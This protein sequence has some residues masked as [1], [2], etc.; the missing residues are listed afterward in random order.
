MANGD[1]GG[2]FQYTNRGTDLAST[3]QWQAGDPWDQHYTQ[4]GFEDRDRE[5]EDY[6]GNGITTRRFFLVDATGV[7]VG[8]FGDVGPF[9]NGTSLQFIHNN[10]GTTDSVI[11]WSQ[12]ETFA[13]A[14]SEL[15]FFGPEKSG[16][17]GGAPVVSFVVDVA[18]A[19][20]TT[21]IADSNVLILGTADAAGALTGEFDIL[22]SGATMFFTTVC[23]VLNLAGSAHAE[24]KASAFT[25]VS[26][27]REKTD[28]E[29]LDDD[30][31][32]DVVRGVR[33]HRFRYKVRPQT[34]IGSEPEHRRARHRI[35]RDHNCATDDCAGTVDSP[36]T[37]ILNDTPRIGLIAEDVHKVAPEIT[38]LDAD[39]LPDSLAV[40][41]VAAAAFGAVGALLR[42]V[43]ALEA[44]IAHLEGL[45]PV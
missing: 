10:P 11:W 9:A 5:L 16:A 19:N 31:L 29:V 24:I 40:D 2:L 37:L 4:A 6:L 22:A 28:V 32:L 23:D 39:S 13:N 36:C 42:K 21:T 20:K 35:T 1:V 12:P 41:Q 38:N 7:I 15:F 27:L 25:V 26:T 18:S 8:S 30:R 43:E 34:S 45:T 3:N 14:S 44:R 17:A 33:A